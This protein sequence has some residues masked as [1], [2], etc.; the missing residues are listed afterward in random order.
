ML[1]SA[2]LHTNKT[3]PFQSAESHATIQ[4]WHNQFLNFPENTDGVVHDTVRAR[5]AG[6]TT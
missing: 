2:E 5:S 4:L 3:L 1:L 6:H